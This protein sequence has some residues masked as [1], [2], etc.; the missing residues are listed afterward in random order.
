M[1]IYEKHPHIDPKIKKFFIPEKQN[2]MIC[3]NLNKS[4]LHVWF[5]HVITTLK[6]KKQISVKQLKK[7]DGLILPDEGFPFIFVHKAF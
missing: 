7:T 1:G 2:I 5:K 3:F 6:I 4:L